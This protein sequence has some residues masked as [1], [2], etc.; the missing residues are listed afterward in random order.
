MVIQGSNNPFVITFDGAIDTIQSLIVTLWSD[1]T[2]R[3]SSMI[4]KWEKPDMIINGDTAICPIT[5]EETKAIITSQL[6]LEAKGLDENGNTIFWD[7][8]QLDVKKRRDRDISFTK[9]GG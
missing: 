7:A 6:V 8:Y 9:S 2:G 1:C 5:E 4:K 3:P